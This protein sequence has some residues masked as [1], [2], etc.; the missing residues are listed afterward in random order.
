MEQIIKSTEE[1]LKELEEEGGALR[2]VIAAREREVSDLQSDLDERRSRINEL[3]KTNDKWEEWYYENYETT[4]RKRRRKRRK[5]R[6][7]LRLDLLS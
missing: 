2:A 6:K 7:L 5:R 3:E 4:R 1:K